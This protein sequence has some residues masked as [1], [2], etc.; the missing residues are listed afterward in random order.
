M[1]FT[2]PPPASGRPA[3]GR[4]PVAGLRSRWG[5]FAALGVALIALGTVALLNTL[6][7][8]IASIWTI[9]AMMLVGAALQIAH[10]FGVKTWSSFFLWLLAGVVYALGGI[11]ALANPLLA[12]AILT[13]LLAGFLI[14]G[15]VM[16]VMAGL[17]AKADRSWGWIVFSGVVTLIAGAVIALGWPVSSLWVLGTFLAADLILQGWATLAF[18]L[19]L[20]R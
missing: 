14:A 17:R 3:P 4:L 2:S 10:A 8:T 18:G 11:A 6:V 19:A 12:S 20:R 1:S 15:G 5:W 9:A 7:A 16:R 13:L